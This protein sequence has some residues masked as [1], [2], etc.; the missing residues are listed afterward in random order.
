MDAL[1]HCSLYITNPCT[2]HSLLN[3]L[4]SNYNNILDQGVAFARTRQ[5]HNKYNVFNNIFNFLLAKMGHE[6]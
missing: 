2:A 4:I 3:I 5:G 6:V 1:N